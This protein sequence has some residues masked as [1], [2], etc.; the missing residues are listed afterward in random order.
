MKVYV[1]EIGEYDDI[2]VVGV[3]SSPGAAMQACP[4]EDW[5]QHPLF[6]ESVGQHYGQRATIT[7]FDV[8]APATGR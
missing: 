7:G 6:W 3:Y 2:S 4:R 1:L 5:T 8:D